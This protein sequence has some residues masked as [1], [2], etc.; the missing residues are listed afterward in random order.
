MCELGIGIKLGYLKLF[1]SMVVNSVEVKLL[2][3]A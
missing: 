1:R 2:L 3:T